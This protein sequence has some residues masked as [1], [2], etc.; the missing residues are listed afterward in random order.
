MSIVRIHHNKNNPYV[1]LNKKALEDKKLSWGAKGLWAYLMS[2][3]DN[4]NVSVIHLSKIYDG[5]GGKEKAIYSL[6]N[7]LIEN[8]YCS[9]KQHF[10]EKG[11]F[12]NL[13]Y[14]IS[15]FKIKV[16]NSPQGDA[17]EADPVTRGTNKE[18]Y[19]KKKEEH[20]KEKSASPPVCPAE[21]GEKEQVIEE[22]IQ[23][24]Q[25]GNLPFEPRSI[26][27]LCSKYDPDLVREKLLIYF[28]LY[29]KKRK[30]AD[31]PIA[32]LKDALKNN[33]TSQPKDT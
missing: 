5:K 12:E 13:E 14:I 1:Q 30:N 8:G 26:R 3:P 4:W 33:Y 17:G 6:L 16:P 11:Q 29:T 18:R 2:R 19:T 10:N 7:E 31:I 22:L 24:V 23:I 25:E 28:K 32:W 9:K 20:T 15:E 27:T 21:A